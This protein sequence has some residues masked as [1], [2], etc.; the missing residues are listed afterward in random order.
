MKGAEVQKHQVLHAKRFTTLKE[1][2]DEVADIARTRVATGVIPM[3]VSAIGKGDK[4]KKGKGKGKEEDKPFG[5]PNPNSGRKCFYCDKKGHVKN[6]C[7]IHKADMAKAQREGKPF[8]DRSGKADEQDEKQ[9]D[10]EQAMIG[11]MRWLTLLLCSVSKS[12][13][14]LLKVRDRWNGRISF[15]TCWHVE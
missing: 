14:G 10:N 1:V 12:L 11:V 3:D 6:D 5:P 2:R 9:G 4:G 15:W 8:I 7:R 13:C